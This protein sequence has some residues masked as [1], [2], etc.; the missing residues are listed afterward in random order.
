MVAVCGAVGGSKSAASP[1]AMDGPPDGGRPRG[2]PDERYPGRQQRQDQTATRL[3]AAVRDVARWIQGC[4]VRRS[5]YV[6][7]LRP[8]RPFSPAVNPSC[9]HAPMPP[10]TSH[11]IGTHRWP[12][13]GSSG[14]NT[15]ALPAAAAAAA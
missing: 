13:A 7:L 6:L 14:Y 3:A 5:D 11:A 1:S 12:G 8:T 10:T 15:H 9:T 2:C 4:P